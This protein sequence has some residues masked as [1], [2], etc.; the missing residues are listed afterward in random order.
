[1]VHANQLKVGQKLVVSGLV[2]LFKT[3][4]DGERIERK[5][6]LKNGELVRVKALTVDSVTVETPDGRESTFAHGTGFAKLSPASREDT[7]RPAADPA[8]KET[9]EKPQEGAGQAEFQN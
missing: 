7:D 6:V 5:H 9:P 1:M 8:P 3:D 4:A 2:S